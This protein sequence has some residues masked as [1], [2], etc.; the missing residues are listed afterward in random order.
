MNG[1]ISKIILQILG[2]NTFEYI[3]AHL[4]GNGQGIDIF[5]A[6]ILIL[7]HCGLKNKF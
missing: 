5:A 4:R 6:G 7:R 3:S 2:S 1:L